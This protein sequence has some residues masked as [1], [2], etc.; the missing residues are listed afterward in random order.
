MNL[1]KP[2]PKVYRLA[3]ELIADGSKMYSCH[4]INNACFR[5]NISYYVET[6]YHAQYTAMFGDQ[7]VFS[8]EEGDASFYCQYPQRASYNEN[9]PF[10]DLKFTEE[11]Q[12][13]RMN[14]LLLMA[15]IVENP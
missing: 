14:A 6:L 12:Q 9:H 2:N 15:A 8:I 7:E 5:L 1:P 4:A 11:R 13:Y 10:W 3:A